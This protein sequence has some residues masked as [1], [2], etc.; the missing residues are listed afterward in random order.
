MPE[1]GLTR[2]MRTLT[3]AM[4]FLMTGLAAAPA[5]AQTRPSTPAPAKPVGTAGTTPASK[6]APESVSPDYRLAFGDKLRIEVYR[7]PQLSQSVEVR[8][9]G[10]ITLPLVGDIMAAG[11]TPRELGD[12]ITERLR[13]Y[14]TTPV[15]TVIV[16]EA[17]PPVVYVMGEVNA[18]GM[19]PVRAPITVLQA[20]AVAGGFKE[21]ANTKRI[22]I[23]RPGPNG[24]VKTIPFNYKDALERPDRPLF[25]QPGD[26]VVVP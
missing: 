16:A 9:D 8:P 21:F 12:G 6:P 11:T 7:E 22:R 23:L 20:L 3:I 18:P 2:I 25:L 26:T 17:M 4:A 19:Q 24:S 15:V 1:E 14:V 13:E 5:L 10:K